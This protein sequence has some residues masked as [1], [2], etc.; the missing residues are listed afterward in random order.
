MATVE[1][2][3]VQYPGTPDSAAFDTTVNFPSVNENLD[4]VD[5]VEAIN[6]NRDLLIILERILGPN[7]QIGAFTPETQFAIATIDQR[8]DILENGLASGRFILEEINVDN[9]FV[10]KKDANNNTEI[11]LG[12]PEGAVDVA[13]TTVRGPMIFRSSAASA[14]LRVEVPFNIERLQDSVLSTNM[15]ITGTSNTAQPLLTITDFNDNSSIAPE[16]RVALDIIGNLRIRGEL[17]VEA[18]GFEHKEL[19]GIGTVPTIDL[20]TGIVE[21][22]IIHVSRGDFHSHRK[23]VFDEVLGRFLVDS[24]PSGITTGIIRHLDLE[25]ISPKPG[26]VGFVPDPEVA[27]H[28]TDGDE[29]NHVNGNGATLNHFDL[30]PRSI[31]PKFSNHVTGGDAHIHKEGGAG[32]QVDHVNLLNKGEVTHAEIDEFIKAFPSPINPVP[33]QGLHMDIGK[34]ATALEARTVFIRAGLSASLFNTAGERR[35]V[36]NVTV[37][38]LIDTTV[39]GAN[40][41]DSGT[42]LFGDFWYHVYLI[43]NDEGGTKAGLMS[44]SATSP[45]LPSGFTTFRRLGAAR[46]SS[47]GKLLTAYNQ[48][49]DTYYLDS[50]QVSGVPTPAEMWIDNDPSVFVNDFISKWEVLSLSDEIPPTSTRGFLVMTTETRTPVFSQLVFAAHPDRVLIDPSLAAAGGK[51]VSRLR[52]NQHS[53]NELTLD[54]DSGQRI[55]L[56]AENDLNGNRNNVAL[57]VANPLFIEVTGYKE[58]L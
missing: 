11:E 25:D 46:T 34:V 50:L 18:P 6:R 17:I 15:R 2:N 8:L 47:A 29:H 38:I 3:K 31:D 45:L 14:E 48:N 30:D 35:T 12:G 24:N 37:P 52:N 21:P 1:V 22:N 39:E 41:L 49:G 42:S 9:A 7:P 54:T 4:V 55:A 10:V 26:L 57:P 44:T 23:G 5:F 53:S 19:S 40:G 51:S 33:V 56:R 13:L 43:A 16:D 36:A 58:V 20:S 28:V 32:T 27:Y